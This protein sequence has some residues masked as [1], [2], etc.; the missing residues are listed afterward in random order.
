MNQPT[1]KQE[2]LD[3]IDK[4]AKEFEFK[5]LIIDESVFQEEHLE[6][7]TKHW[8]DNQFK[9]AVQLLDDEVCESNFYAISDIIGRLNHHQR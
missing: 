4:L 8:T 6:E 1:N 7:D 9:K 5:Y 2:A 3:L